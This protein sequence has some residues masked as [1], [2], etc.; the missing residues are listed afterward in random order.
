M[1]KQRFETVYGMSIKSVEDFEV[2]HNEAFA[3]GDWPVYDARA[4]E[5]A[6]AALAANAAQMGV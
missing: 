1:T 2:E 6:Q 3:M 5:N 4:I